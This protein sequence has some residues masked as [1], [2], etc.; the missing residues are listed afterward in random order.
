MG[1]I[2]VANEIACSS[3][4]G[5]HLSHRSPSTK[6]DADAPKENCNKKHDFKPKREGYA[7]KVEVIQNAYIYLFTVGA[8]VNA[9]M[10]SCQYKVHLQ[11]N[12]Y[13]GDALNAN[14]GH[15]HST[16][17]HGA[18]LGLRGLRRRESWVFVAM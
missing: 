3:K 1:K 12:Q 5:K 15:S 8:K 17:G 14:W 4:L 7:R 16:K 13:E 10:K 9:L 11:L 18:Y 2:K 6:L